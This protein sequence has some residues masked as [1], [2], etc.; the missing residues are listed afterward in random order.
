MLHDGYFNVVA[1]ASKAYFSF[2]FLFF[3]FTLSLS[4]SML[5]MSE[6][7][8]RQP[9]KVT[10]GLVHRRGQHSSQSVGLGE[11]TNKQEINRHWHRYWHW[12]GHWTG[13][14]SVWFG[15]VRFGFLS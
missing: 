2:L 15:S 7:G 13:H 12:H 9:A 6:C 4:L 1:G 3:F 10:N 11:H 5:R 8:V 14:L